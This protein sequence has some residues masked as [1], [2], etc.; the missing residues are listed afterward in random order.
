MLTAQCICTKSTCAE[1]RLTESSRS[2][3]QPVRNVKSTVWYKHP[4]LL[5]KNSISSIAKGMADEAGLPCRLTNHSDRHTAIQTLLDNGVAPTSVMQ[6][7]G[8]KRIEIP[9]NYST[10]DVTQQ[11]MSRQLSAVTTNPVTRYR[12]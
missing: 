1:D 6:L 11:E 3:V 5:G 4:C 12:T 8:H 10:T 7:S 9:H 2:Y